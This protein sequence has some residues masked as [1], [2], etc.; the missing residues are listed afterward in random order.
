VSALRAQAEE[1][2]RTLSDVQREIETLEAHDK[3]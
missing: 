3:E 2:K 1:L